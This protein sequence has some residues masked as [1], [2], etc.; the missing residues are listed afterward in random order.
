MAYGSVT[1]TDAA[2]AMNVS[3]SHLDR[4]TAKTAGYAPNWE[5]LW[6]LADLA[7]L[8]RE[9]FSADLERLGDIVPEDMPRFGATPSERRPGRESFERALQER[10]RPSSAPPEAAPRTTRAPRRRTGEGR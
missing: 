7:G 8:P 4:F 2:A 3:A 9:W 6:A 1:R 5:Q 10:A